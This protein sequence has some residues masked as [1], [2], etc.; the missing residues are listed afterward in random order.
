MP[1][2]LLTFLDGEVLPADAPL[3]DFYNPILH[4]TSSEPGGNNREITVP[5]SSVKYVVFGGEEDAGV[6]SEESMGKVVIHFN[7]HEVMRAYASRD[8]LGGPYGIIYSL[9]DTNKMVR[10]QIGVPYTAVKAIF[11]VKVWDSRQKVTGPTYAKV[12]RILSNREEQSR[13]ERAG[14]SGGRRRPTPLLD[15]TKGKA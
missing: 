15:R 8:V 12:A 6:D 10:R 11:K 14:R 4:V 5:L 1:E 13:A 7:D 9:L 2:V 3:I